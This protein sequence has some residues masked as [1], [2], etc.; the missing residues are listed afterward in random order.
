M[1]HRQIVGWPRIGDRENSSGSRHE[2]D[3]LIIETPVHQIPITG[4]LNQIRGKRAFGHPWAHPARRGFALKVIDLFGRFLDERA[5]ARLVH[6]ALTFGIGPAVADD[7]VAA[8]HDCGPNLGTVFENLGIDDHAE[9][10]LELVEHLQNPPESDTVAVVAPRE[11]HHV[12]FRLGRRDR[13]TETLAE[14]K[15]FHVEGDVYGQPLAV[16][17]VI[18]LALGDRNV[19]IAV[20]AFQHGIDHLRMNNRVAP[21]PR[22]RRIVERN[23]VPC[24]RFLTAARPIASM[25]DCRGRWITVTIHLLSRASPIARTRTVSRC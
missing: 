25:W 11:V 15:L 4:F 9:G 18:G 14:G 1:Q 19:R 16:G 13:H 5:F 7:F 2:P 22:W 6:R 20:M 8:F 10:N 21:G 12:R 3:R 24:Q 17:P 23:A